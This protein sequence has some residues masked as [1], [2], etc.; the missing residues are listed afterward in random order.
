MQSGSNDRLEGPFLKL[1]HA[2]KEIFRKQGA[3]TGL[4]PKPPRLLHPRPEPAYRGADRQS[5]R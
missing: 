2:F 5:D 4:G 3:A 1:D